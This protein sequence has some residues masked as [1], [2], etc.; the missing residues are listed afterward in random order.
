MLIA[1]A[2]IKHPQQ[3]A[4]PTFSDMNVLQVNTQSVNTSQA[5]LTEIMKKHDVDVLLLQEIWNPKPSITFHNYLQPLWKL[6][7]TDNYGQGF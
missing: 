2:P 5:Q 1:K 4:H 6:R 7:D 3:A